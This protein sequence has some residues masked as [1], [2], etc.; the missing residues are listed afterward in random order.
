MDSYGKA[1]LNT[2]SSLTECPFRYQGQYEDAETGLYYNRFRY[3]APDEGMYISQ[4]PITIEG[5]MNLYGYVTDTTKLID[6]AGL[7]DSSILG[8]NLGSAPG[9]NHDAHHIVM[10]NS[11]DP[12]MKS[13]R[14][15][16]DEFKPPIG[17]NAKENG[18]W[19][20][21]TAND[22]LPGSSTTAHK[23]DG[24]H[25]EAYKQEMFERLDGKSRADFIAEFE[26]IN[27]ELQNGKKFKCKK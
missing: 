3:Y 10:A 13:L 11:E 21:R 14:K 20:P 19:L 27:D 8:G 17:K 9:L 23:G 25:G 18:I 5:G 12:R 7:S 24:I 15:Q 16:M 2:G 6:V 4:D 1:R 26:K 22:R